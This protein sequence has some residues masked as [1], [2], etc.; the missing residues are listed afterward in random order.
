MMKRHIPLLPML[1]LATIGIAQ[2]VNDT[3]NR[4]VLVESTYNPIIAG[5]VKR[6]FIPEEVRPSMNKEQVVYANESVGLIH[7]DRQ[8]QPA[9]ATE[10]THEENNSG[11][12]H[13]G[14]GNYNNL[15]G[16]AAY[17]WEFN[18]N[19]D[20]AFK[21]HI[22]G[23]NGKFKLDNDAQWRSHLYN[24]GLGADYNLHLGK[25]LL[26]AGIH[27]T[28]YSY[29]YLAHEISSEAKSTQHAN[30]FGGYATVNGVA[31]RHYYYRATISYTH[32]MRGLHF[33]YK[34]PHSENHIHGEV[35]LGR[36]FY[37][38][39][40]VSVSLRSDGLTYQG[41][42]DY[43]GYFSMSVTPSWEYETG[44]FLFVSGFNM[45]I[46][47]GQNITHPFQMSPECRISYIP[48]NRF[49]AQLTLDGGRDI[50]TFG[51]L[52]EC[53]PYWA[54]AEQLRPTYTFLN[55]RLEGGVRI[56]EGLH[57]RFGGEYKILSDALF[58]TVMDS[59][60]T[61]YTGITN[62]NA[63]VATFGGGINY[64]YKDL[65]NLSAKGNYHYWML[66]GDPAILARA[67]QIKIDVNARVRILPKLHAYT[68]LKLATFTGTDERAV[69][70]WSIG[71]NYALN[72]KFSLFLD[73]HNLLNCR[74]SYYTGY[75]S[76]GFNIL[77]GAIFKF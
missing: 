55:A 46:L 5:A 76:Q 45:D 40:L 7:F 41:P 52:Y 15:N 59:A 60:G 22:N 3:I 31:K 44:N 67:P 68:D 6:N 48:S 49:S 8:A 61:I 1:L 71:S 51:T 62:H 69:I 57:L 74:Y 17:K 43:A 36:N 18:A 54:S 58:E 25:A 4:M 65:V 27:A 73:A 47:S 35:S 28:H 16:I 2:T 20:L 19:N 37:N 26:N 21:A 63:Q 66:Q 34:N 64:V 12:A 50:H 29:N 11:Y 39:G 53:S 9:Q 23:W 75:P 32:F 33:A 72:K 42:A 77:G 38:W 56:I 24:T 13:L 10:L 30:D 14:Y 70:D